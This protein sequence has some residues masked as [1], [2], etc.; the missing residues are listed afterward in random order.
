[1]SRRK[2]TITIET[3]SLLLVRWPGLRRLW[4]E[5]CAAF[6]RVATLEETSRLIS[7]DAAT[8]IQLIESEALHSINAPDRARLVCFLSIQREIILRS[9]SDEL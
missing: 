8:L 7:T 1:M 5:R 2:I 4:C 6:T 3:Y 9:A